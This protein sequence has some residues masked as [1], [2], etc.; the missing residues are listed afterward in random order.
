M[1]KIGEQVINYGAY[2]DGT[3]FAA[4][5]CSKYPEHEPITWLFD[6]E[7]E[8]L[9]LYFIVQ[10]FRDREGYRRALRLPYIPEARMDREQQDGD[11]F[12]LKYFAQLL[13]EF[14]FDSV[15]VFDPHS[16][17]SCALIDHVHAQSPAF[18]INS[19]LEKYP[20]ALLAMPDEGSLLRLRNVVNVPAVF[21]VKQRNWETQK[22]EKLV[23]GGAKHN[24]AGHDILIA[25]DIC[26]KGSTIYYMSKLLK[27]RGAANIYVYVS[28][29]ENTVLKPHINGQSLLDIPD[30]ITKMYTT[31]SIF[32]GEHPKIEVI[33][34]F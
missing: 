27:E 1:I 13:N 31:N 16:D 3:F 14:N 32:R 21:G 2:A 20:N 26:G 25:D 9:P 8:F 6:S 34:K 15:E 19:L 17:V 30:L 18:L 5:D 33:H 22:V 7:A 4:L 12:T 10:H 23:L 24:I 29:C 28:H 11:V